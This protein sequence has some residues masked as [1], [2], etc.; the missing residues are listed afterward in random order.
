LVINNQHEPDQIALSLNIWP[1]A[2]HQ[3]RAPLHI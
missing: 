3:F 1:R 2:R